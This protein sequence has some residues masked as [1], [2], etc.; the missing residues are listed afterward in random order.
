MTRQL[1]QRLPLDDVIKDFLNDRSVHRILGGEARVPAGLL[2]GHP[3][4]G[5]APRDR[6][7]LEGVI[8]WQTAQQETASSRIRLV[9]CARSGSVRL[10]TLC[11]LEGSYMLAKREFHK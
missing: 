7:L 8:F 4:Y 6:R 5:V 3:H 9:H 11:R 1:L 10:W 2:G